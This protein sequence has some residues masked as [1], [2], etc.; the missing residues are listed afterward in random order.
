V[1]DAH[2]NEN[3]VIGVA[4]AESDKCERDKHGP[5]EKLNKF[6]PPWPRS[7]SL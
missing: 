5:I 4:S 1:G 7:S 3:L 2:G 6:G